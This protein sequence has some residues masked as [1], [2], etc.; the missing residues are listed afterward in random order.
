MV[1]DDVEAPRTAMDLG[2]N[3]GVNRFITDRSS[4]GFE[5][6]FP[7]CSWRPQNSERL[8]IPGWWEVESQLSTEPVTPLKEARRNHVGDIDLLGYAN[9]CLV[10]I[11]DAPGA[12]AYQETEHELAR[13]DG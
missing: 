10:G 3:N 2:E 11:E 7:L 6:R 8:W 5:A 13:H 4:K 12:A 1:V 9:L